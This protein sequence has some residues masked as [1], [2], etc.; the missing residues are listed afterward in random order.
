MEKFKGVF[1]ALV[2][3]FKDGKIDLPSFEKLVRHQVS[4]GVHGFVINGTTGESPTLKRQEIEDLVQIVHG[5]TNKRK[6]II[7]GA[8]TNST[9]KTIENCKLAEKLEVDALLVVVPYY[10][11]P[12]QRGL[13]KHFGAVADQA[14]LP[15]FLYNVPGRTGLALGTEAVVELSKH[16]NILGIKEA[17]GDMAFFSDLKQ[18]CSESF[19]M[20]S[21][22]DGTYVSSLRHGG[23]GVISVLSHI[24]P[25]PM[26]DWFNWSR[27]G[28][29]EKAEN[30][31]EKYRKLTELLFCEANPIPVKMALKILQLIE[32]S[33]LRLPLVDLNSEYTERLKREMLSLSLVSR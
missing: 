22:D 1:T 4:A 27:S 26:I 25:G 12:P 13:V 6:P 9:E 8:G 5:I 24:I 23:H 7:L 33:E 16:K 32:T 18:R 20:L 21:G 10:N 11:K 15:V 28:E 17:S 29:I 30:E 3:P 19:L 14:Q 31:F 2:S